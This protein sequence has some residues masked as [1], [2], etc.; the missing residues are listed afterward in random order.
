V[1]E[2]GR[3]NSQALLHDTIEVLPSL[4]SCSPFIR[5]KQQ[6]PLAIVLSQSSPSS[7]QL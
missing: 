1:T 3:R 7:S 5:R 6:C 4:V 2:H